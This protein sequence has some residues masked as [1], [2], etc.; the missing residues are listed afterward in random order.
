M[1]NVVSFI[2]KWG[3]RIS[4][5]IIILVFFKTCNT[6]NK[7]LKTEEK[8]VNK[9]NVMDST[10]NTINKKVI[11]QEEMV[12]LIKETPFWKSL[13]LE[14][15]SDKNRIPINQLKNNSENQ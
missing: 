12:V 10:V 9:L 7:I 6:N 3:G 11:S 14:E 5:V 2:D 13:E 1:K 4:F 8:V 15:L